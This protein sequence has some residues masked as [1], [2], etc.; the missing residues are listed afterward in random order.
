VNNGNAP[1]SASSGNGGNGI[2]II[3]YTAGD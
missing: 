3:R 2:V 1:T